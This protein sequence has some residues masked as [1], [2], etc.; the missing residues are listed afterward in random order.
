M[1]LGVI[2]LEILGRL[3]IDVVLGYGSEVSAAI[4]FDNKKVA[5]SDRSAGSL[6]NVKHIG[7][8]ALE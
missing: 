5:W 6:L 4:S 1:L 2:L 8:G 7:S 3:P